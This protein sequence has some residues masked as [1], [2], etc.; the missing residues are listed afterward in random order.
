MGNSHVFLNGCQQEENMA[1]E[2]ILYLLESFS[3]AEMTV[4]VVHWK[5]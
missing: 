3:W 4:Y 2:V 1:P 5:R